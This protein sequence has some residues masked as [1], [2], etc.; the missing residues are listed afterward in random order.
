MRLR[1]V[2]PQIALPPVTSH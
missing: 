1:N 2:R